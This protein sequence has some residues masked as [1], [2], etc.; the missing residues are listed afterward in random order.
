MQ[1]LLSIWRK[2]WV[3]LIPLI[4]MIGACTT[5]PVEAPRPVPSP[6]PGAGLE[7]HRVALGA[8]VSVDYQIERK[9]SSINATSCYAFVS[10]TLNNDSNQ[11][12]SRRTVIDFNFF[13]GGKQVFRDLTSPVSDVPPGLR[14]MFEMV[15][16]P[17]HRDG[18]INYDRVDVLLRKV[19]FN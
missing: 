8:G 1:R 5:Q 2:A 19:A 10:G 13:S 4:M 18:C 16:S 15:V 6:L 7:K 17:V 9:I 12:L 14:V 3:C 11:T